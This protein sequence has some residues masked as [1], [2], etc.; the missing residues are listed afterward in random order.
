MLPNEN[1]YIINTPLVGTP[2]HLSYVRDL[3]TNGWGMW[4]NLPMATS[5]IFEGELYFGDLGDTLWHYTGEKDAVDPGVD[6]GVDIDFSMLTSFQGGGQWLR[7][8]FCRPHFISNV[9][10]AFSVQARWDFD[11]SENSG[12]LP[13]GQQTNDATWDSGVWDDAKWS[14]GTTGANAVRGISN[15]GHYLAVAIRGTAS[16]RLQLLAMTI[17][18][19]GGDIL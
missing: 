1:Q 4:R 18:A 13:P 5:D 3:T 12:N 9:L 8:Q 7:G 2:S 6:P 15:Y 16:S 11:F 17:M 19:Q 10:P 14:G